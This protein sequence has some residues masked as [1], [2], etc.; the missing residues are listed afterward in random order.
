MNAT[1]I[2][3]APLRNPSGM[4]MTITKHG[5]NTAWKQRCK[6]NLFSAPRLNKVLITVPDYDW[7]RFTHKT[8]PTE[9]VQQTAII[10]SPVGLKEKKE[11]KKQHNQK[12]PSLAS[13][14]AD[15]PDKDQLPTTA[16]E[17]AEES[18]CGGMQTRIIRGDGKE[19]GRKEWERGEGI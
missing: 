18:R 6:A 11:K 17:Q 5:S 3:V 16:A 8:F 7:P 1:L 13:I 15:L 14:L 4:Q 10:T 19:Q 12:N 2:W 9:S